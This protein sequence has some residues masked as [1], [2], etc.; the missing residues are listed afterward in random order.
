MKGSRLRYCESFC[1]AGK[2]GTNEEEESTSTTG[3]T[4]NRWR[5]S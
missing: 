4:E 2:V 3:N 5:E 1:L